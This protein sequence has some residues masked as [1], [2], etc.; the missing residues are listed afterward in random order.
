MGPQLRELPMSDDVLYAFT[1]GLTRVTV[2][3]H[4]RL[5]RK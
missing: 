1:T 3:V 4:A 5:E 2:L